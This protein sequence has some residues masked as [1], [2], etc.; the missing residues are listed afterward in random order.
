MH[1]LRNRFHNFLNENNVVETGD[2]ILKDGSRS[3][4]F[5][6][7]GIFNDSFL[8][9]KIGKYYCEAILKLYDIS[10]IDVLFGPAYKGIPLVVSTCCALN[11]H[12]INIKYAYNRKEAKKHGENSGKDK[13][14]NNFFGDIQD[15]DNILIVDDVFTS[16]LTKIEVIDLIK[17]SFPNCNI[18]GVL[19]GVNRALI[20]SIN[21]KKKT[22]VGID[23]IATL[24]DF[25]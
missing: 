19:V 17:K 6:N 1:N 22:G 15:G 5:V 18:E 4:Y 2:F 20:S 13:P 9:K 3:K 24:E 11:S 10:R 8:I 7:L 16:G 14:I 23:Y 25:I 21:F 12:D